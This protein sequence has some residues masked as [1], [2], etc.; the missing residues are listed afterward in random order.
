M[1]VGGDAKMCAHERNCV[2]L[3]GN[4]KNYVK[5]GCAWVDVQVRGWMYMCVGGCTCA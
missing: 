5:S 3:R 4:V 1:C 2:E